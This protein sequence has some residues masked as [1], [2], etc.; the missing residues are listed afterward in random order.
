MMAWQ[1]SLTVPVFLI[2]RHRHG[3]VGEGCCD[4][5][6]VECSGP[7][8][9]ECVSVKEGFV[10]GGEVTEDVASWVEE[11]WG[12]NKSCWIRMALKLLTS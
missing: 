9:G 5:D 8:V 6:G 4:A 2:V 10:L 3:L 12:T 1:T 7:T 11:A